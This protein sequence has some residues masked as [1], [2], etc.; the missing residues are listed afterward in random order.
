LNERI[1]FHTKIIDNPV[2][3]FRLE[4]ITLVFVLVLISSSPLAAENIVLRESGLTYSFASLAAA[5]DDLDFSN[6]TDSSDGITYGYVPQPDAE[7][8][9][10]NVTYIRFM[11]KGTLNPASGSSQP[12]FKFR[13]KVKVQ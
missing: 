11:P 10:A 8:Y 6:D 2:L 3:F 4:G 13:Y 7:G 5:N 12:E 9:D 1:T